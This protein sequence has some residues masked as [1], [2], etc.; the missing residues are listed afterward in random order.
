MTNPLERSRIPASPDSQLLNDARS[1][2]RSYVALV[3][4]VGVGSATRE[5]ILG[6]IDGL[7]LSEGIEILHGKHPL[8]EGESVRERAVTFVRQSVRIKL[9]PLV[10]ELPE[11]E[12]P[13][14]QDFL[15]FM[16]QAQSATRPSNARE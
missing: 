5:K 8:Y 15:K 9:L 3:G 1:Q 11:N 14:I 7:D 4:L 12:Q 6:I 13:Q 2:L 10:A 16:G